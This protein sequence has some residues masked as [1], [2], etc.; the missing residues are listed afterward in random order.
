MGLNFSSFSPEANCDSAMPAALWRPRWQENEVIQRM[1]RKSCTP[2]ARPVNTA[3][4]KATSTL[5]KESCHVSHRQILAETGRRF[6][7]S[8][9]LTHLRSHLIGGQIWVKIQPWAKSANIGSVLKVQQNWPIQRVHGKLRALFSRCFPLIG[10]CDGC[11]TQSLPN[12]LFSNSWAFERTC[13]STMLIECCL[14][15]CEKMQTVCPNK[16]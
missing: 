2:T 3:S 11:V 8:P 9:R 16:L 10:S 13:S 12:W 7:I 5:R 1:R 4:P 14:R 6:P 15:T